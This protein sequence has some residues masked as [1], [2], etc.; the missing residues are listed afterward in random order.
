MFIFKMLKK[1]SYLALSLFLSA[2]ILFLYP[3]SQVLPQGLNNFRFWFSLLSPLEWLLYL[4]YGFLF[5]LTL[6]LFVFRWRQ[7][8]CPVSK[9]FGSGISG[10]VG[11]FLGFLLPQCPACFSLVVLFLPLSFVSFFAAYTTEIM[12]VS[13][14]LLVASLWVLGAFD[15][16]KKISKVGK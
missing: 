13:V 14:L 7:K 8:S 10:G 3:F 16:P 6:S 9:K 4:L 11:T 15:K 2:L 5:G 12:L 1:R